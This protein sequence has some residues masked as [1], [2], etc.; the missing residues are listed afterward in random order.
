MSEFLVTARKWRPTTFEDVVGQGHVTVTLLNAIRQGRL[1][2]AYVFSGPRGVGKTTTARLLAK[3]VNCLH[4]VDANPDNVC[5]LCVEINS[6]QSFNVLEIDGA[7][8]RGIDDIRSLRESVRFPPAKGARK[9]YIVDEVHM[10]TKEAFNALLKTLEEPP[11]HVLFI[12]ATTEIQKLPATILSRCQRFDFRRLTG[13]EIV[14]NLKIIAANDKI[15]LDDGALRLIARKADGSLRDAQS[16]FDQAISLCGTTITHEDIKREL[17]IVDQETFF[18]VTDI[19][20]GRDAKGALQLVDEIMKQGYDPNEFVEGIVE[21]LRNILVARTTGSAELIEAD[22]GIRQRYQQEAESF[23]IADLLRLQRL[24]GSTLAAIRWSPQPRFKLEADLVQMTGLPEA[25]DVGSLIQKIDN[26][27]KK[28]HD[29]PQPQAGSRT[30][31]QLKSR[32]VQEAKLDSLPRAVPVPEEI[33]PVLAPGSLTE[34][35]VKGC[36]PAFVS[37]FKEKRISLGMAL[38]GASVLAVHGNLIKVG[39][40]DEFTSS[41]IKRYKQELQDSL[42]QIL[43]ARIQIEPVLDSSLP[44]TSRT[45]PVHAASEKKVS[46][47]EHPVVKAMIRELG[48]EPM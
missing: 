23:S 45:E 35:S 14:G 13:D 2:H 30:A 48:A 25:Q 5:E 38:D 3:A 44:P 10:L 22:D 39:C 32:P 17:R 29:D 9:V 34:E 11:R 26:L 42:H 37:G 8:N 4:P 1:A 20:K 12:F 6:G 28:A 21:H 41:S 18:R 43:N 31:P 24:A 15:S 33:I 16:L 40:R 36:W 7:S 47:E 27:K 19:V 46:M